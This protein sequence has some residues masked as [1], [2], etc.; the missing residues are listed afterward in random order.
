MKTKAIFMGSVYR[1]AYE[2]SYLKTYLS[3]TCNVTVTHDK[4]AVGLVETY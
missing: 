2:H 3:A 1:S 4:C